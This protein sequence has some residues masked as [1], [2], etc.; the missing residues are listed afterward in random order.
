VFHGVTSGRNGMA[1][2]DRRSEVSFGTALAYADGH[3]GVSRPI[4]DS[5]V[6][7]VPHPT[8]RGRTIDVNQRDGTPD[9]TTDLFGPAVLPNLNAYY[10]HPVFVDAPNLPL[11]Y[12]LGDEIFNVRPTFRSGA[13][14]VV[15]TGGVAFVD[16]T[17]RDVEGTP[18]PL[19]PGTLTALDD[20]AWRTFAFFT[21]RSGRL[22]QGGLPVGR[23]QLELD[24]FPGVVAEFVI[25]EGTEGRFALGPI[26][27]PVKVP[28]SQRRGPSE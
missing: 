4:A 16:A 25:P 20:R 23:Y 8:L 10:V 28:R 7:V 13:T 26:D 24:N 11:G 1:V 21:S 12:D 27:L 19:E 15:G 2:A 6:L 22:R 18:L 3:V 5:F 14:I 17:L 9:A